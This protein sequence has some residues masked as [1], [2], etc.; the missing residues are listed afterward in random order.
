METLYIQ[1]D[2]SKGRINGTCGKG[3]ILKMLF[4][5]PLILGSTLQSYPENISMLLG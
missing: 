5:F 4:V 1:T 2:K 3:E